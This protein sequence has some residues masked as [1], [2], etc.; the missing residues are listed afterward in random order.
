MFQL[1]GIDPRT[2]VH[3]R[4]NRPLV[5][6]SHSQG[7]GHAARLLSELFSDLAT[8]DRRALLVAAYVIGWTLPAEFLVEAVPG[9]PLCETPT[10]TRCLVTYNTIAD[11]TDPARFGEIR[12][13][14]PDGSR[15]IEEPDIL[16]VN[17]VSW[18]VDGTA[19]DASAHLGRVNFGDGDSPEPEPDSVIAQ[20]LGGLLEADLMGDGE[21]LASLRDDFHVLDYRLFYMNIRANAV[22]RVIAFVP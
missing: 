11:D 1:L 12:T 22:E 3:D 20:C 15:T 2:E 9:L 14:F 21:G 10:Q 5:I 16:C 19:S 18:S 8:E 7:S 4:A 6:A 17:P 13:W